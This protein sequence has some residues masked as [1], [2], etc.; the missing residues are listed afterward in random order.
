MRLEWTMQKFIRATPYTGKPD[1][2]IKL[3]QLYCFFYMTSTVLL[4]VLTVSS[5]REK[6]K[7]SECTLFLQ[8]EHAS[9]WW[10]GAA[11]VEHR[12]VTFSTCT[13]AELQGAVYGLPVETRMCILEKFRTQCCPVP[14]HVCC[15][16]YVWNCIL[17][18]WLNHVSRN[19]NKPN[20]FLS[21]KLIMPN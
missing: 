20:D 5:N 21:W 16:N 14:E 8:G 3:H 7:H 12:G 1:T 19:G 6:D 15:I 17:E 4:T 9:N 10:V 13:L 11:S 2:I 18:N